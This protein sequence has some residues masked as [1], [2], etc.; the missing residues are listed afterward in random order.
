[1]ADPAPTGGRVLGDFVV[2]REIGRGGMGVVYRAAHRKSGRLVA[3]KVLEAHLTL[4][5][6]AVERFDREAR[7]IAGL[8]HPN[9]VPVERVGECDGARYF[10][11]ELIDGPSLAEVIA[12]LAAR[13]RDGRR[14]DERL[15]E[16]AWRFEFDPFVMAARTV[17]RVA[18]ALH[19]AHR[20]GILHRDVKP[21]NV[22]LRRDGTPLLIDFG[23]VFEEGLPA[24]TRTGDLL[25]SPYYVAPEQCRGGHHSTDR[26][27][28]VYSLGVVLYELLAL[29]RPFEGDNARDVI[30]RIE[31]G[32]CPTPHRLRPE[33]PR[34]LDAI[35]R[36]AMALRPEERYPTA[37]AF[38]RDLELFLAGRPIEEETGGWRRSARAFARDHP[39]ALAAA[40]ALALLA[41]AGALWRAR[42]PA[43]RDAQALASARLLLESEAS[44]VEVELYRGPGIGARG[45]AIAVTLPQRAPLALIPGRYSLRASAPGHVALVL[46]GDDAFELS[47][48]ATELRNLWL[49][50]LVARLDVAFDDLAAGPA[51]G[52]VD[53]DG[54]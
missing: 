38:A 14:D 25:G 34:D 12:T 53:G 46:E 41:G 16:P 30:E 54:G 19:Y 48:G 24:L 42:H 29:R 4:L 47:A 39:R 23:L 1:M 32:I 3:L 9:I 33:I 44:G 36:R 52:D 49:A 31:S 15:Q 21:S 22:L 37:A 13:S 26:R 28:D 10:A 40:A 11:M 35:T 17:A 5:P 50:P 6:S 18:R 43:E 8:R 20:R 2:E 27:V 51:A 7:A 45:E